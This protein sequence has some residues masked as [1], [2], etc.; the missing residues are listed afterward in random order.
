MPSDETA[1]EYGEMLSS[2][3]MHIWNTAD[4]IEQIYP[5]KDKIKASQ[6]LG[7]TVYVRMVKVIEDWQEV[8]PPRD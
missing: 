4:Y 3:G 8:P 7:G 5:V 2:G 6:R 1:I